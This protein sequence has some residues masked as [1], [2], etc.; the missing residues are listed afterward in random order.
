MAD[1]AA[2]FISILFLAVPGFWVG[3]LIVL[4][5]LFWFGYRAPMTGA[6]LFADPWANFAAGDRPRRRA[7]A[8]ARPPISPAWA[9]PA[10]SR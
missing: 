10:C 1:S 9:A 6:S 7:R 8:W 4:A 2:R 5:L 3:M